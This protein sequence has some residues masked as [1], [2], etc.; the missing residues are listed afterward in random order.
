MFTSAISAAGLSQ[1]VLLSSN[2]N[3][4]PALQ[5]LQ[6]SLASG[7]LSSAQS[8]FQTLES[9]LQNSA[10]ATGSSLSSNSQLSSDLTALETALGAGDLSTAQ[11]AFATL[12][13]YLGSSASPAQ[14]NEATAA[15][16]SVELVQ[17]LLGTVNASSTADSSS[18]LTTSI[19]ESVYGSQSA[20]NVF[21]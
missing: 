11:S 20:L 17:E 21:G 2:P 8:A 10:T 4:Q 12:L 5:A 3:Q 9:V 7:D 15:T 18:D 14:V 6:N 1:D 13:G 19:L 16:Q